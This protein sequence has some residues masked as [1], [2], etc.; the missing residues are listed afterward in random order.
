MLGGGATLQLRLDQEEAILEHAQ[1]NFYSIVVTSATPIV[2]SMTHWDL[3][4]GGGWAT[5][6]TPSGMRGEA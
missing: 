6:G 5:L 2:A 4:Q 1:L 3:F